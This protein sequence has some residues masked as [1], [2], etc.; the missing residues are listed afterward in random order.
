[1]QYNDM[2]NIKRGEKIMARNRRNVRRRTIK[3]YLNMKTFLIIVGVLLLVIVICLGVKGYK[4]Y[5]VKM[6][7]AIQ[8]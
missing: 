4:Q 1:M 3:D 2:Q 5:E 6:L 7:L 8:K